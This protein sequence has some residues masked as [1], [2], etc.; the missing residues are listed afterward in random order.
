MCDQRNNDRTKLTY[1]VAS[2]WQAEGHRPSAFLALNRLV[3]F[4]VFDFSATQFC[5]V[6]RRWIDKL[7]SCSM[8]LLCPTGEDKARDRERVRE[9]HLKRRLK[10]KDKEEVLGAPTLGGGSS[11]DNDTESESDHDSDSD[12]SKSGDDIGDEGSDSS[13]VGG[14]DRDRDDSSSGSESTGSV[15][16]EGGRKRGR[17]KSSDNSRRPSE[18]SLEEQEDEVL[19]MLAARQG[20]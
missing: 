17:G 2:K 14:G 4:M 20:K 19:A 18:R 8:L 11:S 1:H 6:S 9:K 13:D 16:Q 5:P 10:G 15:Q 3:F 12:R 7:S